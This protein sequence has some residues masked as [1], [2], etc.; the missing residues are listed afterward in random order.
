MKRTDWAYLAGLLD[1]DGSFYMNRNSP[2]IQIDANYG[3]WMNICTQVNVGRFYLHKK[4]TQDQRR[5]RNTIQWIVSKRN[6]V[7]Y[8]LENVF[9]YLRTKKDIARRLMFAIRTNNEK[10]FLNQNQMTAKELNAT[11]GIPDVHEFQYPGI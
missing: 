9:P 6:D 10:Y 11:L 3:A 1:A 8:I 5:R 2:R 4:N 7:L